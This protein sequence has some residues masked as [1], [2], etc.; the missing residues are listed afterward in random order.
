MS[1]NK[2][3]GTIITIYDQKNFGNRLQNYA[4]QKVLQTLNIKTET[5]SYAKKYSLLKC[6]LLFLF[7]RFT[8]YRWSQDSPFWKYE[9]KRLKKFIKFNRKYISTKWIKEIQE[10][11]TNESNY[12]ILGSDQVWNVEWYNELKKDLF[13]LAF[14]PNNKKICYAPSFGTSV[15]PPQWNAL[16]KKYM[17]SMRALSS[18]EEAGVKLIKELTGREAE[19]LIDP[20]LLLDVDDWIKIAK[21]PKV[22]N[23]NAP[24]ILTYFLGDMSEDC[25]QLI[26]Q[27]KKEKQYKVYNLLEKQENNIY[28]SGPSEFIYL[29]ANAQIV[30]TDSFHACVFSFLFRKPFIVY[31]RNNMGNMMSRIDTFLNT[32]DL[33]RK[34]AKN[35][36]INNIFEAD[37]SSGFEK[38]KKERKK[39]YEYLNKAMNL[40]Y[41]S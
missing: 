8:K 26:E 33:Q 18:R 39:S 6:N 2:S 35:S 21:K 40:Q 15:L 38:L 9:W 34:Y 24:Y 1:C 16:F 22:K 30:L 29:F 3:K 5:I 20:T 19:L 17:S 7:H 12:F 11:N 4:L 13:L 31:E 32:F 10:I 41:Y 14:C 27:I 36:Q 28:W 37:Y 25:R 23:I